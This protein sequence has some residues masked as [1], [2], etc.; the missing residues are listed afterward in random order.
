MK[1]DRKKRL[2]IAAAAA[3]ALFLTSSVMV[4]LFFPGGEREPVTG[5]VE[6]VPE[7]C[8]RI[9]YGVSGQGRALY[10]YL[11]GKGENVLVMT[12]CIHG[13]EDNFPRDGNALV[14]TAGRVMEEIPKWDLSENGWRIYVLPCCNPDGLLDGVSGEGPGRCTTAVYGASGELYFGTGADINRCF[15][16]CWEPIGEPRYFNGDSPLACPEAEALADFIL[17]VK[18]SGQNFC[19]D[20]HGWYQQILPSAGKNSVL[21]RVFGTFFP[22]NTYA[23]VNKGS[24]YFAAY[25]ALVGY[26]SCLFEFPADVKSMDDFRRSGYCGDFISAVKLLVGG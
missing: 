11:F 18:G 4:K 7:N 14:Y 6:S 5:Y 16:V 22:Q 9:Q 8:E 1:K 3:A 17:E 12:F 20:V 13:F 15:P 2:V 24:G 10:A 21:F 19:I 26:E 25:A 23:D